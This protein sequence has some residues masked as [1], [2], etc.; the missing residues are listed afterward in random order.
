MSKLRFDPQI[1]FD[2]VAIIIACVIAA[3]SWGRLEQRME[4]A[5]ETIRSHTE[6]LKQMAETNA[7]LT[8]II[9]ER[10]KHVGNE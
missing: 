4:S 5:E 10:I 2:G 7:R 6:Q 3:I 9:D 8:A 1:S